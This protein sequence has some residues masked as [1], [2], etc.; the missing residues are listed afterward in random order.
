MGVANKYNKGGIDWGIKTDGFDFK[1]R[2]DLFKDSPEKVYTLRGVYI[3]TK[4][5][6]GDHPV[7]ILDDCFLDLPSY[8]VDDIRDLRND[9]EAVSQILSGCLGIKLEK[10]TDK[11]FGKECI[12]VKFV[13][14]EE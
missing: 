13:D 8:M 7:A 3:Y 9:T 14:I 12:G 4:G 2:D 11:K 1:K 10:Y 6:F 5:R